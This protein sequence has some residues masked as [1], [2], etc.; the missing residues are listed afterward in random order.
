MISNNIS[1]NEKG[2]LTFA[3][4]DTVKLAEK[5]G[6]TFEFSNEELY[7]LYMSLERLDKEWE[8]ELKKLK[9]AKCEEI[10]EREDLQVAFEQLACYFIFRHFEHGVGFALVSC[11]VLGMI[12]SQCESFEQMLD[13]VRMYSSEIE[14]SEENTEK[15]HNLFN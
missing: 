14:Y 15:V 6:L 2:H 10:F 9:D 8:N 4:R 11:W 5:Y 1:V 7:N 3:S 12:F 13:V